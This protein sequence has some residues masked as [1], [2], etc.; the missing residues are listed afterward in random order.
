[1]T[2][3]TIIGGTSLS[4]PLLLVLDQKCQILSLLTDLEQLALLCPVCGS[5]CIN[6]CRADTALSSTVLELLGN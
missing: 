1:M 6:H 2:E 4:D 3:H 5:G